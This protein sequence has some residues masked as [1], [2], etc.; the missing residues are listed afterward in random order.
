MQPNRFRT[1]ERL[2]NQLVDTPAESRD[3]IL[4]QECGEDHALRA[5][6]EAMLRSDGELGDPTI[7]AVNDGVVDPLEQGGATVGP[8]RIRKRLAQG[9]MGVVYEAEQHEPIRRRV[10]LKLIRS[11]LD[12]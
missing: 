3:R 7:P 2:F 4:D 9:G 8:Y 5:E 10:A 6:V 1:L 12:S 11:G